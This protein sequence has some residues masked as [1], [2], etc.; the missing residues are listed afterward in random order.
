MR[1]VCEYTFGYSGSRNRISIPENAEIL[2]VGE[3]QH[4]EI[5]LWALVDSA[6]PEETRM[7]EIY[8]TG[9]DIKCDQWE[10]YKY[11]ATSI[12]DSIYHVFEFKYTI[13]EK[14]K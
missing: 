11:I 12:G 10:T 8:H 9:E 14:E 4:G 3:R 1:Q 6:A 7:F 13:N 2:T 5:R